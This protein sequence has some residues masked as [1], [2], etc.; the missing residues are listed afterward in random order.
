[1]ETAIGSLVD[2]IDTK[3]KEKSLLDHPFYKAWSAGQLSLESLRDY[4]GQYYQHVKAFPTY[5]SAV[6]AQTEDIS[7]RR[8]ILQNLMDE[9]AGRPNHPDLWAQF[10]AGLGLS[11]EDIESERPRPETENLIGTFKSICGSRGTAAGL[12]ALYAYESQ[13]PAVSESKIEGLREFYGIDDEKTLEYFKVH[14][15]ADKEHAA[16]ERELLSGNLDEGNMPLVRKSVVETLDALYGLL[17]GVCER[18]GRK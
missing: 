14:I 10:A 2:E 18:H 9:E 6:H 7:A 3:V 15:E 5:L 13:I 1:M 17:D 12:A 11:R 16:A 8:L 4:A